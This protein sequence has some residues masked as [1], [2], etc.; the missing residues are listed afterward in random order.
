MDGL[1]DPPS[2]EPEGA[3]EISSAPPQLPNSQTPK[4]CKLCQSCLCLAAAFH[5]KGRKWKGSARQPRLRLSGRGSFTIRQFFPP[6]AFLFP[7][8]CPPVRGKKAAK[9]C[10]FFF[11]G[12]TTKSEN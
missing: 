6:S 3:G 12:K 5:W 11:L 8:H 1:L 9:K 7:H 10:F 2:P 4:L